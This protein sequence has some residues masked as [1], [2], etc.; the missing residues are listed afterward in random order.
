MENRNGRL[1][2]DT[3][4]I[5]NKIYNKVKQ[6]GGIFDNG[7]LCIRVHTGR[8]LELS[9]GDVSIESDKDYGTVISLVKGTGC[10]KKNLDFD[11]LYI[12]LK[13]VADEVGLVK[14]MI[15]TEIAYL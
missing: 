5:F 10:Y 12:M 6:Q 15:G 2:G 9:M 11:L 8:V 1:I 7:D 3:R 4:M 14:I 13:E